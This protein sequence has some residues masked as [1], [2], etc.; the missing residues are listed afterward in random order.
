M[1][2]IIRTVS[3]ILL[4]F[5]VGITAAANTTAAPSAAFKV[6]H[7]FSGTDGGSPDALIQGADGY[8]YGSAAIGV[9]VNTCDPDGCGTLFKSDSAGHF[10]ALH[11]FHASDGYSPTG[12]VQGSDGNFYGT[13]E[14]GASPPA[15]VPALFSGSTLRE[16]SPC[17]MPLSGDL[18]AATVPDQPPT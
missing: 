8:F 4:I 5:T 14:R 9:D 7:S 12:L 16:T 1:P 18:P 3:L 13:A 11:I 15:A 10:A 2:R 17:C 6:L